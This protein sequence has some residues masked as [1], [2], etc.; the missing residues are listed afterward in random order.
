[1]QTIEK[2][3]NAVESRLHCPADRRPAV[4]EELRG[5]LADRANV[6]M[7]QGLNQEQAER[8]A[9]RE[10]GPAWVLALRLSKA[11]GWR[12]SIHIMREIWA[13]L[14]TLQ[15]LLLVGVFMLA[16][17]MR[18]QDPAPSASKSFIPLYWLSWLVIIPVASFSY[19]MACQM[20]SI[21][22]ACVATMALLGFYL[23]QALGNPAFVVLC[24]L[25][26][27]V[28]LAAMRGARRVS[29]NLVWLAWA[30]GAAILLWIIGFQSF[31]MA[32]SGETFRDYTGQ[33]LLS[34][35]F[36]VLHSLLTMPELS[37]LL[38]VIELTWLLWLGAWALERAGRVQKP[39]MS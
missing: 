19:A 17:L 2:Y 11:S 16:S 34:A 13:M 8:Q 38:P 10:M 36:H 27:S 18:I 28:L 26:A 25:A 33:G 4:I 14:L 31:V 6:L 24:V 37:R 21:I 39:A 20:R 29:S 7:Q 32:F 23:M 5:H 12:V 15:V 35:F 30:S 22:W 3:L 1:M 9:V